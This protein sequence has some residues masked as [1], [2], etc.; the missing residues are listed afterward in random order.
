MK[1]LS[2][3]W[4]VFSWTHSPVGIRSFSPLTLMYQS[5]VYNNGQ[6]LD[7]LHRASL[8]SL[9][10]YLL[11]HLRKGQTFIDWPRGSLLTSMPLTTLPM[12]T[13][14]PSSQGAA[15]KERT[16]SGTWKW[17]FYPQNPE[18]FGSAFHDRGF[19]RATSVVMKNCDPLVLGPLFAMESRPGLQERRL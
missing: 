10:L 17:H 6:A 7:M 8:D 12:T 1:T 11:D 19:Q 5:T 15:W 4:R 9:S 13:C 18:I 16:I 3:F 2:C 14:L